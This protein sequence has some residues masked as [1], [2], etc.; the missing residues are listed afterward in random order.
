M[1][2]V[3]RALG[4]RRAPPRSVSHSALDPLYLAESGRAWPALGTLGPHSPKIPRLAMDIIGSAK[5]WEL[6]PSVPQELVPFD[7]VCLPHSS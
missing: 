2:N 7:K 6:A 3:D 1:H 5:P 4:Q